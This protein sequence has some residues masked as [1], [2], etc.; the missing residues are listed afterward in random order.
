MSIHHSTNLGH[1]WFTLEG[2]NACRMTETRNR[3]MKGI[4]SMV[5]TG[6]PR[7]D[8]RFKAQCPLVVEFVHILN[9]YVLGYLLRGEL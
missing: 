1:G 6:I 7:R 3:L 4:P 8:D 5:T 2:N 9:R